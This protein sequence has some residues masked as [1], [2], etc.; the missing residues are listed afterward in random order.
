M[1]KTK[2]T[3]YQIEPEYVERKSLEDDNFREKFD[4]YR[5]KT[6]KELKDIR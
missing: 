5:I 2:C 6:M 1:N 4:F 3:K